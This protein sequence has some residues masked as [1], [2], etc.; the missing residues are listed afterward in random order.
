VFKG[1]YREVETGRVEIDGGLPAGVSDRTV[2]FNAHG[3]PDRSAVFTVRVGGVSA[4]V[5]VGAGGE[6]AVR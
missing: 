4:E 1:W 3:V 5:G 6:V 2:V